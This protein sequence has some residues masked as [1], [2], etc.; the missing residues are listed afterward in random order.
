[1]PVAE[2]LL[3]HGEGASIPGAA[4]RLASKLRREIETIAPAML[5][6][7]SGSLSALCASPSLITAFGLAQHPGD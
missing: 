4:N 3:L 6:R 1:E 5:A 2:P 7:C